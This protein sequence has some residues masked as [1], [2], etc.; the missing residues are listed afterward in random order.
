MGNAAVFI[1]LLGTF[2]SPSN[3]PHLAIPLTEGERAKWSQLIDP[4]L[5]TGKIS[6]SCLGKLIG[7]LSFSSA[8]ICG[9]FART[10]LRPLYQQFRRRVFN[11]QLSRHGRRTLEWRRRIIAD[12][13]P[14][15]AVSLSPIADWVIYTDAASEPPAIC[16]RLFGAK[17]KRPKMKKEC[18][19]GVPVTWPYLFRKTTLIYGLELLS[20]L[21]FFDDHAPSLRWSRCWVYMGNNNNCLSAIVRGDSNTDII[22][23]LVARFWQLAQRYDICVWFPRVKS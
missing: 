12:F 13:A 18:A 8:R 14:R 9:E 23:V 10:Q 20:I 2:P 1:G 22:A 21:A 17:S 7:R 3:D 16:A 11:D 19:A 5:K 6:R 4:Y 15:I